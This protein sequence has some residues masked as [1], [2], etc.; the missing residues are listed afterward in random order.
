M[1]ADEEMTEAAGEDESFDDILPATSKEPDAGTGPDAGAAD[2]AA[3]R[4]CH[5][6]TEG[7]HSK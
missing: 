2:A 7:A 5:F 1:E 4:T 3:T 6:R